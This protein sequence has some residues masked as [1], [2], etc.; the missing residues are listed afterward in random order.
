MIVSSGV[1][2]FAQE[3]DY[4]SLQ[5]ALQS[6]HG[7]CSHLRDTL[8]AVPLQHKTELLQKWSTEVRYG[9][10]AENGG[11]RHRGIRL[12]GSVRVF[13]GVPHHDASW[14]VYVSILFSYHL[15]LGWLVITADHEGGF[16]LPVVP[17]ILTHLACLAV[18]LTFGMGHHFV[19]FFG[20]LRFGIAG[21]AIFECRWLF[22]GKTKRVQ[23][24]KDPGLGKEAVL[25]TAT[26][27]DYEAWLRYLSQRKAN[28]R[29]AGTSV[30]DEYEQWLLARAKN[31]V[32]PLK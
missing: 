17:T 26:G 20:I 30:K 14:S 9:Y 2:N 27:E 10:A 6:G 15:F 31:R 28:S 8:A 24:L 23:N 1:I 13:G 12:R 16:S 11:K 7:F 22:S 21:L 32:A 5:P 29:K 18:I 25:E 4:Q 3:T 19:P